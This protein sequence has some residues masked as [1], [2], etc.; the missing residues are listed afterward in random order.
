MIFS[1]CGFILGIH[2]PKMISTNENNKYSRKLK[3]D[4]DFYILNP[5]KFMSIYKDVE[6]DSSLDF[7]KLYQPLQL[8]VFDKKRENICHLV[9]CYIGGNPLKWNRFNSFDSIP[10]KANGFGQ[11]NYKVKYSEIFSYIENAP[12]N[13]EIEDIFEK[14]DYVYFIYYAK[15]INGFTKPFIKIMH[16]YQHKNTNEKIKYIYINNDNL[17]FYLSQK[18]K[19]K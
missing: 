1:S 19:F 4:S 12:S 9:N 3:I 2:N 10:I 18:D 13:I 16:Q 14:Y 15:F 7:S 6:S 8:I 17:L 11:P 5:E